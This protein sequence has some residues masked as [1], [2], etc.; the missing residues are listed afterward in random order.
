MNNFLLG[1]Y[2]NVNSWLVKL[3]PVIKIGSLILLMVAIFLIPL[4]ANMPNLL[5]FMS[6]FLAIE[7]LIISAKISFFKV[8]QAIK[9]IFFLISLTIILQILYQKNTDPAI[10]FMANKYP[11]LSISNLLAFIA[12]ILVYFLIKKYIPFKLIL[13][14]MVLAV[15]IFMQYYLLYWP[16]KQYNIKLTINNLFLAA[17]LFL[18][19]GS[20]I[21]LTSLLTY[22]TMT[23]DLNYGII[24]LLYPLKVIK[25]PLETMAMM[26]SLTLRFIPTI[27]EETERV[28]KAQASRGLDFKE[29][30]SIKKIK[31]VIKLLIPILIIS[32]KKAEDLANAMDARGYQ[33]GAK[34]TSIDEYKLRATDNIILILVF[35]ILGASIAYKV[36]VAKNILYAV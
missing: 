13:F 33:V 34:R 6:T 12:L 19:I 36:L 2:Q 4:K 25:F 24:K 14:F 17:F 28:R 1:S 7:L 32:F 26:F 20:V 31:A 16:L 23:S 11:V 21:L 22:T 9:P 27:F 5:V 3:N 15:V 29:I 18:R 10:V 35:L 8:L 30:G